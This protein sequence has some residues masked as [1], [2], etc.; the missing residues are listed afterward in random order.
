MVV[1]KGLNC[2]DRGVDR[3]RAEQRG[4]GASEKPRQSPK[5]E[6]ATV[7]GCRQPPRDEMQVVLLCGQVMLSEGAQLRVAG[8]TEHPLINTDC[9]NFA[10]VVGPQMNVH[11]RRKYVSRSEMNAARVK[12]LRFVRAR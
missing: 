6:Q 10:C 7:L 8:E 12:A 9:T 1:D 11:P 3:F 2:L 4:Q 5:R